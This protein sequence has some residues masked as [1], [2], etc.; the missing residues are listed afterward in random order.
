MQDVPANINDF[1]LK[2]WDKGV[3]SLELLDMS[4]TPPTV[5]ITD[6]GISDEIHVPKGQVKVGTY[7]GTQLAITEMFSRI[8][9][10]YVGS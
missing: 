5:A 9:G 7:G 4:I 2:E 8:E 6:E 3:F 10:R 1:V